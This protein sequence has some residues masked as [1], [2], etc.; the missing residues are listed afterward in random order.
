MVETAVFCANSCVFPVDKGG[1][2]RYNT[3]IKGNDGEES[4]CHRPKRGMPRLKASCPRRGMY[5]SRAACDEQDGR[6]P[7]KEPKATA[8]RP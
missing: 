7:L 5:H 4:V 6:F 2:R 8:A 3:V 1:N